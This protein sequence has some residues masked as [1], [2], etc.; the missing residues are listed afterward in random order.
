MTCVFT[1]ALL[2]TSSVGYLAV[3]QPVADEDEHLGLARRQLREG[4]RRSG[5]RRRAGELLDQ[6][7][8]DTRSDQRIAAR[9]DPDGSDEVLGWRVLEEEPTRPARSAS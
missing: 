3:R 4:V 1:V 9:H 8:G 7:L 5:R 2:T 6:P